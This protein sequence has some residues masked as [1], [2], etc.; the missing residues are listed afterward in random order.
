MTE[1]TPQ[2]VLF[3]I[4]KFM[5]PIVDKLNEIQKNPET[6]KT[7]QNIGYWFSNHERTSPFMEKMLSEMENN[8]NLSE[9]LET[10]PYRHLFKLI[11][12]SNQIESV[13]ILDLINENYFQKGILDCF[14]EIQIGNHFKSRKNIIEEAFNLYKLDFFAGCLCLIHSQ[15]EGII[16]DYLLYKNIIK[17][18]INTNGRIVL[19]K[20][21]C[22]DKKCSISGLAEKIDLAKK[23]NENFNRLESFNFDN[24]QNIKFSNER[25][26]ILH[27]SNINNFNRER[28][29][30]VFIWIDSILSSMYNSEVV[31]NSLSRN[32][33]TVKTNKT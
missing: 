4:G 23:I 20:T 8:P 27:G 33:N 31:L 5:Q 24:D 13:S 12:N 29:F 17:E 3:K 14:D 9:A 11:S 19:E 28:C 15:L 32:T 26:N 21:N 2:E 30:I 16:T 18:R 7:L 1:N 25:N 10:I 6:M 22:T